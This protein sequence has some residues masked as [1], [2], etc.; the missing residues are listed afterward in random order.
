MPVPIVR[1]PKVESAPV[2]V[3]VMVGVVELLYHL[4]PPPDDNHML[5][6]S[7]PRP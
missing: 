4:K 2:D 3:S 6:D 1:A 7:T 5:A